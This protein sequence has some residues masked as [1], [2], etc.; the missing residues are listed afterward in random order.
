MVAVKFRPLKGHRREPQEWGGDMG[1]WRQM[2]T[3]E[4]AVSE[5]D[6]GLSAVT[7]HWWLRWD[8]E[9]PEG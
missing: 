1:T 4:G 7:Q 3:G 5:R 8:S 9:S 6:R 2:G